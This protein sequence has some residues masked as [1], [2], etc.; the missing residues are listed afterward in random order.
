MVKADDDDRNILWAFVGINLLG[1]TSPFNRV[2]GYARHRC[3]G[4]AGLMYFQI[5]AIGCSGT[6]ESGPESPEVILY[7]DQ[8]AWPHLASVLSG[9]VMWLLLK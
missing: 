5:W 7:C 8:R 1:L 6:S 9:I 3:L 4:D 2:S